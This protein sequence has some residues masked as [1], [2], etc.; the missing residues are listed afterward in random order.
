M[1]AREDYS[2]HITLALILTVA[3]LALFQIY[4]L[5][6]PDRITGVEAQDKTIATTA[7]ELLFQQN[8]TLCHGNDGEGTEGR[9]ALNDKKFLDSTS[10]DRIFS[11]IGSGVP[12][13]EMPAWGQSHGGPLTDE[14]ITNLVSF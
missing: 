11:I 8:C 10:D 6:E 9:P 3:I 12:N 4:I 2:R 5:R 14:N 13:T 7:G 1:R